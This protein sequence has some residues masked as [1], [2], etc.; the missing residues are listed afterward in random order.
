MYGQPPPAY[1]HPLHSME[2]LAMNSL[3]DPLSFT[4][5]MTT[6]TELLANFAV[7]IQIILLEE[8]LALLPLLGD[9]SKV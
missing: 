2:S 9:A 7:E 3:V 5:T 1:G 8:K 4:L 6:M